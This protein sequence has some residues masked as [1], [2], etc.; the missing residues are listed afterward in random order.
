MRSF[1]TL[2]STFKSDSETGWMIKTTQMIFSDQDSWYDSFKLEQFEDVK[3][4]ELKKGTKLFI[5]YLQIISCIT[6]NLPDKLKILLDECDELL[7][8][9]S[10]P[11]LNLN[12]V[13]LIC[14]KINIDNPV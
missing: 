4:D 9:N 7:P 10:L 11:S 14:V 12:E 3:F 1:K 6:N 8:D 5:K 13:T 2:F